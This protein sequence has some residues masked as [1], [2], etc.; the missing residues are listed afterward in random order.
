[1]TQDR[2]QM[3]IV[4]QETSQTST[5]QMLW[6]LQIKSKTLAAEKSMSKKQ[7]NNL[8][9]FSQ[10]TQGLRENEEKLEH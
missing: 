2:T 5:H 9:I 7:S 10:N 8:Q 1:M 4:T 3:E 6:G